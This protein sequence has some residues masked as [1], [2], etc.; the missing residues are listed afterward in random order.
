LIKHL[1]AKGLFAHR[2]TSISAAPYLKPM[3]PFT[4]DAQVELVVAFLTKLKAARLRAEKT[5]LSTLHALFEKELS[6]HQLSA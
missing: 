1:E 2:S 5:L 4:S 6:E 3:P